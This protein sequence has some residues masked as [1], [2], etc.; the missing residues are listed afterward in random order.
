MNSKLEMLGKIFIN[1][2]ILI[3]NIEDICLYEELRV[4]YVDGSGVPVPSVWFSW[5]EKYY[6]VKLKYKLQ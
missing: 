3:F 1:K 5:E 6:H 4:V 2:E